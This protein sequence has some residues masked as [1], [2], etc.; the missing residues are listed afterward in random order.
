MGD[1]VEGD[2]LALY[3]GVRMPDRESRLAREDRRSPY[4]IYGWGERDVVLNIPPHFR[5]LDEYAATLGHKANH[6]KTGNTRFAP[7]YH[8]RFGKIVGLFATEPL[9]AGQEILV[10]YG[11]LERYAATDAV[12]DGLLQAARMVGGYSKDEFREEMKRTI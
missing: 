2:L 10:D 3:N 9:Q 5:T 8:P 1:V 7:L 11:F 6:D 12:L 4:R